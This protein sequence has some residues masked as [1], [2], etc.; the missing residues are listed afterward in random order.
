MGDISQQLAEQVKQAAETGTA[1]AITGGGS[2]PFLGRGLRGQ[3]LSLAEHTGI[4]SYEPVELV[5]TARAGT[6]LAD[7]DAV[8]AENNQRLAFEPPR[9][10]DTDTIGGTLAANLSGP[11]RPWQ[12]SVRDHV[13]GL[14]LINGRGEHLKF[15]GQVMKNVAGYDASRLQAGALGT[16]GVITEV[17]LKVLPLPAMEQTLVQPMAQQQ[18]IDTMNQLAGQP[19]PLSAACWYDGHLYLRLSG[20]ATAV[21]ATAKRWVADSGGEMNVLEDGEAFWRDLRDQRLSFFSGSEPLWRFSVN[22]TAALEELGERTLID[23]GGA[24]RWSRQDESL[25]VMAERAARAGGQVSLFCHGDRSGE[26]MHPQP[27]PL[28]TIQKRLKAAFDPNGI[29]NPGHLYSWL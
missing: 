19:K 9:F 5:M 3:P 8:L 26:V 15:G 14:R 10:G 12:G 2:K 28:R 29:F 7:I 21:E 25:S 18:A 4:V 22:P 16:L 11:G 17:S 1:L 23:W 24:Q 27:S 20:A 13:L 6:R